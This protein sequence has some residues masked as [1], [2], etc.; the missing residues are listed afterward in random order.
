MSITYKPK[1]RKRK[2]VHGFLAR[3]RKKGG[4]RV[5]LRRRRKKRW[6]LTV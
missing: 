4:K 6:R 3:K 2:R 5:I 1:R